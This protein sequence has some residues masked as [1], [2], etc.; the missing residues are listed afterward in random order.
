MFANRWSL[1][2]RC[3]S[4]GYLFRREPGFALG[5]WFLNFML[6]Q[7]IYMVGGLGYIVWLSEH[8]GSGFLLPV[9]VGSVVTVVVPFFTYPHSQTTW[10]AIDLIMTPMELEEIVEAID[11]V[12]PAEESG[13]RRVP[14]EE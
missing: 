9:L 7:G 14:G 3:G 4:C 1:K 6:L 13:T 2:D 12:S 5:A 11:A 10:A 8:R